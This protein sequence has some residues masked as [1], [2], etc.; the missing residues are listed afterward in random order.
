MGKYQSNITQRF[1][2]AS[3]LQRVPF[4]RPACQDLTFVRW[5]F[6]KKKIP[7]W[8]DPNDMSWAEPLFERQRKLEAEGGKKKEV[9]MLHLVQRVKP[10]KGRP[11]WER[12]TMKT[13]KLDGKMGMTYIHKNIPSV[14]KML[15]SVIHLIKITPITFP[16]GIPDTPDDMEN[17]WLKDNGELVVRKTVYPVETVHCKK[18]DRDVWTMDFQTFEKEHEKKIDTKS[19]HKEYF[20]PQYRYK[21]NQDGKEMRYKGDTNIGS[22]REW[23]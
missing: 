10:L 22:D 14:N 19:V 11:Y 2:M 1:K 20:P 12:E 17:C 5:S 18:E 6:K 4:L 23:N 9:S 15:E 3:L 21:Y 7:K 13:L 8:A 16:D